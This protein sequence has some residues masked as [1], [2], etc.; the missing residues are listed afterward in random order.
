MRLLCCIYYLWYLGH[1]MQ[2]DLVS[3]FRMKF[4][5]I[6]EFYYFDKIYKSHHRDGSIYETRIILTHLY[7]SLS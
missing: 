1:E 5:Y 7:K 2:V 4:P 6:L 3:L